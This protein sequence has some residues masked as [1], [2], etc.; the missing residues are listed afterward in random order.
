M[1][2][3]QSTSQVI[4]IEIKK[5]ANLLFT[6]AGVTLFFYVILYFSMH[7]PIISDTVQKEVNESINIASNYSG[8]LISIGEVYNV[9]GVNY[10]KYDKEFKS[11]YD[12]GSINKNRLFYFKEEI[13]HYTLLFGSVLLLVLIGGR[14]ILIAFKWVQDNSSRQD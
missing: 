6:S 10:S 8:G 1:K 7:P 5:I 2:T 4:A 13:N 12:F 11:I 9:S 3:Q 14:Y